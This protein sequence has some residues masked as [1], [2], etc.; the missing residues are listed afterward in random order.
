[1]TYITRPL[2]PAEIQT[3]ADWAAAEGWN[4]G[5]SDAACFGAQDDQGFWGGFLN[6]QLIATISV[7]RYDDSFAFLGFYI[8][9]PDYRTQGYGLALWN[10]ATEHAG[11]RVI[12]L[13]GVVD[14]QENYRASG[15]TFAYNNIRFVASAE[16]MQNALSGGNLSLVQP[17]DHLSCDIRALDRTV[18]PS[19]RDAFWDHWLSAPEHISRQLI[20][21]DKACGFGTIR[22]CREGYKIGPL[23]AQSEQ[24]ARAL[25]LALVQTVPTPSAP[26]FLDVPA[27]NAAARKI[28]DDLAMT[29]VFE[30]AR[31]YRG[32]PPDLN[33]DHI[34]GVTSFE[35]G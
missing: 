4:P 5:H 33:V 20:Y 24:D 10:A 21:N 22:P 27:P 7:V 16:Q 14:Q 8:V 3:A 34:F 13:D 25:I 28:T 31:M 2:S 15:F 9:H 26:V 32:A 35:L 11:A 18:F 30:T 12:G 17:L 23:V 19:N 6:G 1:M 29:N